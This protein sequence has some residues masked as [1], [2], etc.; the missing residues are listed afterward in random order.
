MLYLKEFE[1][2]SEYEEYISRVGAMLPNVSIC[3]D[4]PTHVHYNPAQVGPTYEAVDL[5]L[6]SGKKWAKC[7]IG[8]ETETDYGDYFMWGSTAPDTDNTCNW[9]HA[10]FN[11][12]SSSFDSAYFNAHKSEWLDGDVLKPEYD[13]AHV[14]MGGDW[15]MPTKD[16]FEELLE[17]TTNEWVEN[18]KDSGVNGI[19]F[20]STSN[21]NTMF[22]PAA[23]YRDGS[24]FYYQGSG[25]NV[26]SSLLNTHNPYDA[27]GLYIFSHSYSVNSEY[28]Y[29]G[30]PVRG[31]L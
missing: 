8:A 3:D 30:F 18:Y 1:H 27:Y 14:I 4:E 10:P 2:H 23:G 15:R 31:V 12:G 22:I 29:F 9:A 13:A 20:T 24:S 25:G 19:L 16:D 6:P 17:G 5:G 11:N 26:W 28:H 7:N 21:G